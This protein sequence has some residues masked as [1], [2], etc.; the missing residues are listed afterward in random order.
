[1][2]RLSE[3][4]TEGFLEDTQ[5]Y[6]IQQRIYRLQKQITLERDKLFHARQIQQRK[7]ELEKVRQQHDKKSDND[8]KR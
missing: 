1:M 3:L 6:Q 5:V 7:R 4:V 8:K 2:I